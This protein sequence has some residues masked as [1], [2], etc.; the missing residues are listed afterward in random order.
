MITSE[1]WKT[2]V[3]H[4]TYE[5]SNKGRVRSKKTNKIKAIRQTKTGYCITDL[6]ENGVQQTSYI[7]RMVAQAFIPND[8]ELP[9]INH[10]DEN[11][12]NNCVDNLEWCSASYNNTYNDRAKK[13]GEY[14]KTHHPNCKKVMCV[15]TGETFHSVR[16]A[17]RIT[18]ICSMSISYCL[19]GKQKTAGGYTWKVVMG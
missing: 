7:H 14:H 9:Y 10:K 11:K 19:N 6:K 17:G 18:G 16:M 8:E 1:E 3:G 13:V 2:V 5:V 12:S 4:E 15:E